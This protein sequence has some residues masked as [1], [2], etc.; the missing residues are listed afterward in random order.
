MAACDLDSEAE[1]WRAV[2]AA[3]ENAPGPERFFAMLIPL[4]QRSDG[5]HCEATAGRRGA[6]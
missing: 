2:A 5:D 4:P 6:V 1:Q 3:V